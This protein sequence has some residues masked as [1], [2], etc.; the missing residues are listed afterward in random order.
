MKANKTKKEPDLISEC[1]KNNTMVYG[2][3]ISNPLADEFIELIKTKGG[4]E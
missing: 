3:V 2:F 4:S 1:I